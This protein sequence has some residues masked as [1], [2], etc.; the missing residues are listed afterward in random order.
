MFTISQDINNLGRALS[1]QSPDFVHYTH[2]FTH[3]FR[4]QNWRWQLVPVNWLLVLDSKV[5]LVQRVEVEDVL[6][7]F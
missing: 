5:A 3:C 4:H 7:S 1:F 6:G 2:R